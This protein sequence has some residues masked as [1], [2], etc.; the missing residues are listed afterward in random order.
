[1]NILPT[2]PTALISRAL[3]HLI[4]NGCTSLGVEALFPGI[5]IYPDEEPANVVAPYILVDCTADPQTYAKSALWSQRVSLRLV[6]PRETPTDEEVSLDY[7]SEATAD[8]E[9]NLAALVYGRWP[10]SGTAY[11]EGTR[12]TYKTLSDL[13]TV[14]AAALGI[15]LALVDTA[16][17]HR[18][19]CTDAG[20]PTR[21]KMPISNDD[22]IEF[23]FVLIGAVSDS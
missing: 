2:P 7:D 9:S 21:T 22:E 11:A 5:P 18:P 23:E 15:N 19:D 1:M 12:S 10:I 13:L 14:S 8:Y 4:E 20:L 17:L 6:Q 16:S 3:V